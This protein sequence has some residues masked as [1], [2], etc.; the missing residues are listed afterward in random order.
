MRL[1]NYYY[2]STHVILRQSPALVCVDLLSIVSV[3]VRNSASRLVSAILPVL[4]GAIV[5]VE[6]REAF[7]E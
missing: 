4:S 1:F 3:N 2:L 5:S 7:L 6:L